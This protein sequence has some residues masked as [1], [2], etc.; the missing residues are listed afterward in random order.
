MFS[1][2][3]ELSIV[4]G[5]LNSRNVGCAENLHIFTDEHVQDAEKVGALNQEIENFMTV[6]TLSY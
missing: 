5:S 3:S 2:V 1:N 4:Y 6:S